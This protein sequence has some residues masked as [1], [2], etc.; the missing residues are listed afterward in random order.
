MTDLE[1]SN[2]QKG[3]KFWNR[4]IFPFLKKE[5]EKEINFV[6]EK[7]MQNTKC[8]QIQ[9]NSTTRRKLKGIELFRCIVSPCNH[10]P[11]NE[12]GSFVAV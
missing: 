11:L 2:F 7:L 6:S 10:F 3:R 12:K 8:I 4:E 5:K 1:N 9:E